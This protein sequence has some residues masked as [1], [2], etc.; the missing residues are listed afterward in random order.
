[1]CKNVNTSAHARYKG[2]S[3]KISTGR[4]KYNHIFNIQV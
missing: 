2:H 3:F 4:L 1:M